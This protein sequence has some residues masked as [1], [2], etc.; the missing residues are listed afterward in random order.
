MSYNKIKNIFKM[1]LIENKFKTS[2][3]FKNDSKKSFKQFKHLTIFIY[4]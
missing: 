2:K 3:K 4:C 1:F